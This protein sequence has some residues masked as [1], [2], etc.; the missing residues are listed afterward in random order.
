MY[1][2]ICQKVSD[3]TIIQAIKN[4]TNNRVALMNS[5]GV[6][7]CCGKCL[8]IVDELLDVHAATHNNADRPQAV[9]A[10]FMPE[11]S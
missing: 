6:G 8:P 11:A 7:T 5:L 1:V 2:C 10:L 9:P 4:G 3:R